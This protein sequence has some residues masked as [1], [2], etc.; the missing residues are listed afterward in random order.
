[1][2]KIFLTCVILI[3]LGLGLYAAIKHNDYTL[4]NTYMLLAFVFL[5]EL[6]REKDN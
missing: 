4:S 6:R 1:M 3:Y 2:T 5:N